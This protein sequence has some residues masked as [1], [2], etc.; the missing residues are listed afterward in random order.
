MYFLQLV[1]FEMFLRELTMSQQF[2]QVFEWEQQKK[3]QYF[4]GEVVDEY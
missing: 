4:D 1:V 3:H 2:C